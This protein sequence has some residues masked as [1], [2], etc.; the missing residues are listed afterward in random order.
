[1]KKLVWKCFYTSFDQTSAI[2]TLEK[3]FKLEFFEDNILIEKN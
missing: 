2:L 3:N 1:M